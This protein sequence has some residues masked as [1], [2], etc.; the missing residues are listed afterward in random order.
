MPFYTKDS[1]FLRF[2]YLQ[3]PW[4]QFPRVAEGLLYLQTVQLFNCYFPTALFKVG[5]PG[6]SVVKNPPANTEDEALILVWEDPLEKEMAAPSSS[7]AW[8]IPWTEEP[9]GLKK[10]DTTVS[11]QQPLQCIFILPLTTFMTT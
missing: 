5:F 1:S 4:N 2:C 10:S 6:G 3:G 11:K 7:L 9:S 8:E